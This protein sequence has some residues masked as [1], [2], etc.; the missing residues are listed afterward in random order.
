MVVVR[1]ERGDAEMEFTLCNHSGPG[2]SPKECPGVRVRTLVKAGIAA[3]VVG[4]WR[5]GRGEGWGRALDTRCLTLWVLDAGAA[6]EREREG[7]QNQ[8]LPIYKINTLHNQ[9]RNR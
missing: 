8:F 4:W 3:S 7:K 1:K 2:H 6:P 5:A 9:R